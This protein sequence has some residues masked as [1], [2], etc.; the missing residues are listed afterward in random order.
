MSGGTAFA[1]CKDLD[2][3]W[4]HVHRGA[5]GQPA[6]DMGGEQQQDR[7]EI[8]DSRIAFMHRPDGSLWELG[9]GMPHTGPMHGLRDCGECCT[10]AS[11]SGV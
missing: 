3:H 11:L 2:P 10:A 8:D 6:I 1:A 9:A 4:Q 7:W 5:E